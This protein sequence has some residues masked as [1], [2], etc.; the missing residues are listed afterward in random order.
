MD[1]EPRESPEIEA[2]AKQVEAAK[3]FTPK[4]DLV[5][6]FGEESLTETAPD[7][8]GRTSWQIKLTDPKKLQEFDEMDRPRARLETQAAREA[9][10]RVEMVRLRSDAGRVW[11]VPEAIADDLLRSPLARALGVKKIPFLKKQY[12]LYAVG[13]NGV[14]KA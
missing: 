2:A 5:R 12:G 13:P 6:H 8:F 3:S 11:E 1:Q 4:A 9:F 10:A 14:R 7:E